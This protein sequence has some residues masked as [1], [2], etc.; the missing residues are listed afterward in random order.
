MAIKRAIIAFL[1]LAL[2]SAHKVVADEEVEDVQNID[3]V[4]II[5]EGETK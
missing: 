4:K 2:V 3:G 5:D 1:L